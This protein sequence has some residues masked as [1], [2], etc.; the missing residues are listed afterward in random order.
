MTFSVRNLINYL[1]VFIVFSDALGSAGFFTYFDL[2]GSYF[3]LPIVLI[4]CVLV[5]GN[6]YFNKT[7]I[8]ILGVLIIFS[9][10]SIFVGK[11]TTLLMSKTV[12]GIFLNSLT[13]YMVFKLNNYD[14]KKLFV[15]YLSIAFFAGL[16]GLV[17]ETSNI[18]NIFPMRPIPLGDLPLYKIT[19]IFPEPAHFCEAMMPAFFVSLVAVSH[20][21]TIFDKWKSWVIIISFLLSF[22]A[23]GYVGVLFSMLLLSINYGKIRHVLVGALLIPLFLFIASSE[24]GEI[25][26]RVDDTFNVITRTSELHVV[27][28]STYSLLSNWGAAYH[29]FLDNPLFGGGIGSHKITYFKNIDNVLGI[30]EE[31][32][33]QHGLMVLNAEDAGSLFNRLLSETGLFGLFA[34]MLF[35]YKGHILRINDKS[36]YLWIINNAILAVF[37]IRLLRGGHY[38]IYGFF[39]FFWAYYFSKMQSLHSGPRNLDSVISYTWDTKRGYAPE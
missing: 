37:I 22:S 9:I 33:Q 29:S 6:L 38:F 12:I 31:M 7:F 27:N 18:L 28:L 36:S 34:F 11:N 35:I 4:L 19:S 17:Q 24:V 14:V 16:V 32:S 10:Y 15:I 21:T 1:A 30:D 8:T 5:S 3:I 39:F 2:R 20:S 23:V 25:K 13:F 26:T